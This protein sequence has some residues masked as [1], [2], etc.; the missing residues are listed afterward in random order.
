[1][2]GL[3]VRKFNPNTNTYF[4]IEGATLSQES[5]NG[6]SVAVAT[7]QITDGGELDMDGVVDGN[8][9]DPAGIA[10]QASLTGNLASTGR[11]TTLFVII[12]VLLTLT[13]SALLLARR[14][15]LIKA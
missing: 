11:S 1:M 3:S 14:K 4:T 5:I 10:T 9:E 6:S 13:S 7:Y 8:I 12:A 15:V 2:E